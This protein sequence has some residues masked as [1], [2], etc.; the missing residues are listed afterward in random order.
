MA[1][2][3]KT[4]LDCIEHPEAAGDIPEIAA[5]LWQGRSRLD[6]QKLIGYA[7][8]FQS[9]SLTQRLGFLLDFLKIEIPDKER[10][11]LIDQVENTYC[12][13]GRPGKWGKGGK[14]NSTWQIVD[15]IPEPELLAEINV[16]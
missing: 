15:N 8:K 2:L 7:L 10:Q 1:E 5:M 14:H 9:Q 13:L 11:D 3:E 16:A 12:Y 4:I 6:W